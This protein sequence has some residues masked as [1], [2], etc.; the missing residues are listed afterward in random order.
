MDSDFSASLVPAP[1]RP[2][3][4]SARGDRPAGLAGGQARQPPAQASLPGHRGPVRRTDADQQRRDPATVPH[5]IRMG[6][7][8][9]AKIGTETSTGDQA[10]SRSP[11][12]SGVR[13]TTRSSS[14]SPRGDSSTA[15]PADRPAAGRSKFLVPGWLELSGVDQE[16]PRRPLHFDAMAKARLDARSGAIISADESA[17]GARH[18]AEARQVLR[19]RV[20]WPSASLPGGPNWTLKMLPAVSRAARRRPWDLDILASVQEQDH[21]QLPVRPRRRHGDADRL[22]GPP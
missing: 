5:I 11:E 19:A 15:S 18:R 16:R 3:P 10:G 12:T 4:T 2:A 7:D 9:Y 8:E 1:R 21:R 17:Q 14:A 13:A 20:V 6:G 22:D